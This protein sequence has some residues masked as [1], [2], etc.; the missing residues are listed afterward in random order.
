MKAVINER[1]SEKIIG[2]YF[3]EK[4]FKNIFFK[5]LTKEVKIGIE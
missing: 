2:C 4:F 3:F 5:T 1:E